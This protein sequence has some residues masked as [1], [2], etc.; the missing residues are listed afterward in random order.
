MA[1]AITTYDATGVRHMMGTYTSSSTTATIVTG[2]TYI[3]CFNLQ[4]TGSATSPYASVSGGTIT[5]TTAS[6]DNG[7]WEAWGN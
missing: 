7:Y 5:A 6:S 3:V 2:L 4:S 1:T